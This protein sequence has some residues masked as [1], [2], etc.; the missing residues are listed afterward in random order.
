MA[1]KRTVDY[2]NRKVEG[3]V[4]DFDAVPE[5]WTHY[6]LSDGTTL[7]MRLSLLEVVRLLNEFNPQT[8]EPVYVFSAQN[9]ISVDSPEAL[10]KKA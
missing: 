8:G 1:Q 4:V 10:K 6:K 5:N 2:Q 9:I 3:E 7:K